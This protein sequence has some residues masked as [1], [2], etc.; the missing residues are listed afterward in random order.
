MNPSPSSPAAELPPRTA[1][2][3]RGDRLFHTGAAAL[4]LL[5]MLWGFERFYFHGRAFPD[6]PLTPPIRSLIITHGSAMAV[7]MLLFLLQPLLIVIRQRKTHLLVGRIGAVV[8]L[9]VIYFGFRL[10]IESARVSPPDL[11]IW[12]LPAKQF[13][14][15][16][17]AS[18]AL[19]AGFLGAALATVRRPAAHRSLMLLATM[20]AMSAAISR[21]DALSNLYRGTVWEV[22]FGP[23]FITLLV[24]LLFLGVK[25]MMA[26][27]LDRLY[28][29]GCAGL[30]LA[31]AAIV[32]LAPSAA[33]D[34]VATFL[35]R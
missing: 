29:W 27:S 11:H 32:H 34:R 16:P 15:V 17:I 4:L 9:V 35:L 7:W 26:G 33:W 6:R 3:P 23:F 28:A 13:M 21:I 18:I 12:G 1:A 5:L 2:A 22:W 25:S 20:S 31:S 10:G 19:F 30:V 14:I 8:A 24:A